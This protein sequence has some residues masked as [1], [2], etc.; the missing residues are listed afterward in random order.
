MA[1]NHNSKWKMNFRDLS[2]EYNEEYE[3]R[4]KICRTRKYAPRSGFIYWTK[5]SFFWKICIDNPKIRNEPLKLVSLFYGSPSGSKSFQVARH[6]SLLYS[7]FLSI[8]VPT[9]VSLKMALVTFLQDFFWIALGTN[10][11]LQKSD[12]DVF[13]CLLV[14]SSFCCSVVVGATIIGHLSLKRQLHLCFGGRVE[15]MSIDPLLN[16]ASKRGLDYQVSVLERKERPPL[17]SPLYEISA[18]R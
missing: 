15:F 6:F 13:S 3:K 7:F 12:L 1:W 11:D 14:F 9:T 18:R 5:V 2:E 8:I 16:N 17:F 10:F 4:L